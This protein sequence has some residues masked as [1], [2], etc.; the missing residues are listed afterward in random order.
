MIFPIVDKFHEKDETYI[1]MKHVRISFPEHVEA[2]LPMMNSISTKISL[3]LGGFRA[4]EAPSSRTA[5]AVKQ[6]L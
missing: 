1:H 6:T 5:A 2:A 3:T 4:A